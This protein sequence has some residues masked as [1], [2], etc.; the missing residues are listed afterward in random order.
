MLI[1]RCTT[2]HYLSALPSHTQPQTLAPP[3]AIPVAPFAEP[4]VAWPGPDPATVD[5]GSVSSLINGSD[6]PNAVVDDA[7][8]LSSWSCSQRAFF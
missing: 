7:S 8:R 1:V 4:P 5:L 3:Q 6:R 2:L